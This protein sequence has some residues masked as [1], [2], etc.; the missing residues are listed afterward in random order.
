M[1]QFF[2]DV[3]MQFQ[4]FHQPSRTHLRDSIDTL[5]DQIGQEM[6]KWQPKSYEI[7]ENRKSLGPPLM[8]FISENSFEIAY[9]V[10][11]RLPSFKLF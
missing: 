6:R 9:H 1:N 3:I 10:A 5:F 7:R 4:K 2:D 8:D 11:T